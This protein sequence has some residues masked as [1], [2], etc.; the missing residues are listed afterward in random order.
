MRG[1]APSSQAVTRLR[2][3][4]HAP[5]TWNRYVSALRKWRD[6]ARA[7]SIPWLPADPRAFADF[8][9]VAGDAKH[10]AVAID[11][12]RMSK[13]AG[14]PSPTASEEVSSLREG[15]RRAGRVRRGRAR[16]IFPHELPEVGSP[17]TPPR[18]RRPGTPY[19]PGLTDSGQKRARDG[20]A[21]HMQVLSGAG[22]RFDDPREGQ[23]GDVVL[24][25]EGTH[26][27]LFGSKTDRLLEGQAAATAASAAVN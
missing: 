25:P 21:R 6:V 8:L 1:G 17:G 16:P 23:I 5:E 15:L 14:V 11:A 4:C 19:I 27:L 22:L 3:E 13:L 2:V 9:A 24:G 12:M 10:R 26:L 7:R 20:V 18:H